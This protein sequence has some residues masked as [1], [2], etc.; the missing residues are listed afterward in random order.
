M[1]LTPD[2]FLKQ[3]KDKPLQGLYWF[4][5]DEPYQKTT[6]LQAL[7]VRAK[8]LGFTE[9]TRI[10][11]AATDASELLVDLYAGSLFAAKRRVEVALFSGK[12]HE[13][14]TKALLAYAQKPNP[15]ILLI[16][17]SP[18]LE[19]GVAQG[20]LYKQIEAEGT[21]VNCA[22]IGIAQLPEWIAKRLS[23]LN[24]NTSLSGLNLLAELTEGNLLYA[25]QSIEKLALLYP[26]KNTLTPNDIL[27]AVAPQTYFDTFQLNEA[28]LKGDKNRALRI[29]QGLRAN[30]TELI[31]I[32]GALLKDVRLL[33]KLAQLP[34]KDFSENCRALGIWETRK[35]FYKSAL[36]RKPGVAMLK[37]LQQ[38]DRLI[39]GQTQG[40][41]WLALERFVLRF[42]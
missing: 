21:T 3:V 35:P 22:P 10:D 19:A 4:F 34:N 26:E 25:A 12:L 28:F 31:M 1:K 14:Y 42:G 39:K 6:C 36:S 8:A 17:T 23:D 38:I 33:L 20:R 7:A 40:D 24:L 29:C 32:M 15:D 5:G 37:A 13:T 2:S 30:N 27:E 41:P 9:H 11:P 18:K 16:M